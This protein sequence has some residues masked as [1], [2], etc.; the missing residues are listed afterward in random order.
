M[1]AAHTATITEEGDDTIVR[2]AGKISLPKGPVLVREDESTGEV[3]LSSL[4]EA[5]EPRS[6]AEF[7]DRLDQL[8]RDEHWDNFLQIMEERPMNRL[9]VERN[10]FPDE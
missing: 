2:I 9:P 4:A 10:L 3:V 5:K 6:W 7:F 1:A 8:P